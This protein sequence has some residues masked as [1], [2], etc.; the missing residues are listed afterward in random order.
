MELECPKLTIEVTNICNSN[1]RF[2]A[3]RHQDKFRRG[4][5]V[6]SNDIFDRA[7]DDYKQMGGTFIGLTPFSGEPLID[8]KIIERVIRAKR[9]GAW[10]G[11]YTNGI[12]LN[13]IDIEDLLKSGID[14][15]AVSTG[16]LER[17]MYELL[18]QNKYYEE[19]LQGLRKL[20][21]TR[22]LMRKD[23]SISM[24]FR[25][26]IPMKKVLALPD[27]RKFILPFMTP[28]D[29]KLSIVNTR[30]FDT[31]GGVIKKE[32][33]VGIMRLASPPR[34]KRRPCSWTFGLYLTWDGQVRACACRFGESPQKDGDDGLYLGNI[35]ETS[36]NDI[37]S[38]REIKRLRRRFE[39]GDL[40]PVC[41]KCTMYHPC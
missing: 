22:N 12:L 32:D 21:M 18:Y 6:M 1:C 14:A 29:F 28:G 34:I 10:T 23:L 41:K 35:T 5:G 24:T 33:M 9:I 38:G 11:F 26:H 4:K 7:I 20:L 40:P 15:I 8:P 37:W 16:P 13:H 39:Q 36:L 19:V 31:W 2:C 17:S 27:F 30:G 3:Y 25:S